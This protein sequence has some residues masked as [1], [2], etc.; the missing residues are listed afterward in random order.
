[1]PQVLNDQEKAFQFP[2]KFGKYMILSQHQIKNDM[3]NIKMKIKT[4][5]NILAQMI[6][7]NFKMDFSSIYSTESTHWFE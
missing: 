2:V 5:S 6:I 1:M 4:N 3:F 7:L